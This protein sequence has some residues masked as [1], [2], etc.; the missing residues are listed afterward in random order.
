MSGGSWVQSP[1]WPFLVLTGYGPRS[2]NLASA[3]C[4]NCFAAIRGITSLLTYYLT[5]GITRLYIR[6]V[7]MLDLMPKF[8]LPSNSN[9]SEWSGEMKAWLMQNRLWRLVSGK[10]TR[11]KEAGEALEKFEI[12]RAHV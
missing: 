3:I 9:Y 2:L 11:P 6:L 1:G 10:E 4:Y 7:N 5:F 8:K 12:G